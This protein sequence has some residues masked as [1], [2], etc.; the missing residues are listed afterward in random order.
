MITERLVKTEIKIRDI[1]IQ[2]IKELLQN[3]PDRNCVLF[4]AGLGGVKVYSFIN[5]NIEDGEKSIKYFVDNNPLKQNT[6]MCGKRVISPEMFVAQYGGEAIIIT[7]GEGDDI[8]EQLESYSIPVENVYVPDIAVIKEDDPD[9]IWGNIDYFNFLYDELDDE[10]SKNVLAGILNYRLCHKMQY[11]SKIADTP[12]EQYFDRELI[13]YKTD[14][15]F[16]DCGGYTGDT[17]QEY[18]QHNKGAYNKIICLEAD[19][20]NCEIIRKMSESYHVDIYNVAAYNKKVELSFDKIGSGS[21]M[22]LENGTP[23]AQIIVVE[24]NTIDAILQQQKVTY[25]KMDIEGAE[26]KALLGAADTI[27]EYKPTLMISVYHKQDDLIKIPLLIKSL[28]PDYRLYL[29]HYRKMS[30]Q[31]TVLYAVDGKANLLLQ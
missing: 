8:F 4:G 31:E 26:F 30:V 29:R 5:D 16:L 23:K 14:D 11:V 15:V 9:F 22:I 12:Q 18:V 25:I 7:C 10:K 19:K 20:D 27:Q 28:N 1:V 17:I 6:F 24:G 21:G 3:S 2:Q 13:C